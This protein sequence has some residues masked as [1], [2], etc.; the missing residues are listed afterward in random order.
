LKLARANRA[1]EQRP[2]ASII[3]RAA[4]H[5]QDEPEKTP[6]STRLICPTEEYAIRDLRST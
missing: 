2:C 5:P 6:A 1:E 3:L 4:C